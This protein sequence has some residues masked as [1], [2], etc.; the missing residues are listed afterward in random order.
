MIKYSP[1]YFDNNHLNN[2]ESKFLF[3]EVLESIEK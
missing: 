2:F 3:L 1:L